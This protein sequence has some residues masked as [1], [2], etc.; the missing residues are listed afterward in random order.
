MPSQSI[1]QRDVLWPDSFKQSEKQK[2]H[3]GRMMSSKQNKGI[4][5]VSSLQKEPEYLRTPD[6]VAGFVKGLL[7]GNTKA[8]LKIYTSDSNTRKEILE[9]FRLKENGTFSYEEKHASFALWGLLIGAIA[10]GRAAIAAIAAAGG[11]AA[12][13]TAGITCGLC[14]GA[15]QAILA[16]TASIVDSGGALV[17]FVTSRKTVIVVNI[18]GESITFTQRDIAERA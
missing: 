11:V 15:V 6:S 10:V 8:T 1:I 12:A 9:Y 2:G 3:F 14:P 16:A 4:K 5:I 7:Q 18:T 17:A 13:I